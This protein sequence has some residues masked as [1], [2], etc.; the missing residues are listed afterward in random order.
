M[1][2]LSLKTQRL[3][4]PA[5]P[6]T[7]RTQSS[8]TKGLMPALLAISILSLGATSVALAGGGNQ[9]NSGVLPPLGAWPC[10]SSPSFLGQ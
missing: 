9:G 10:A 7:S 2:S 5:S 3:L 8:L 1:N 6:M 4:K